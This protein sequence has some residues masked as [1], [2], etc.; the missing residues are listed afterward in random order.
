MEYRPKRKKTL[1]YE[2]A[3]KLYKSLIHPLLDYCDVNYDSCTIY[4]SELLD[5][6]Q[7]KASLLCI[8]AF[9]ITSYKK[10]Y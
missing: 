8:G 1:N 9:R 10:K 4:E 6:F 3:N 5:K 2:K 7:R